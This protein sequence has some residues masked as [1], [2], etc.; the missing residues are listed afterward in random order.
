[1]RP[2]PKPMTVANYELALKRL[3]EPRTASAFDYEKAVAFLV[4]LGIPETHIREGSIPETSL[5][6]II[7]VLA[8]RLPPEQ[9]TT[10][11]HVGNYA[12]LSLTALAAA[13]IARHVGSLVV[14]VDANLPHRGTFHTQDIV[15][16]LLDR[17][18]LSANVILICGY[19]GEKAPSNNGWVIDGYD[20]AARILD[21]AAPTGVLRSLARLVTR[22]FDWVLVDGNHDAVYLERD[23]QNLVPLMRPGGLVFL[24]DCTDWWPAIKRIFASYSTQNQTAWQPLGTDGRIGVLRLGSAGDLP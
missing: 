6:Y 9:A 7:D 19:S 20:P 2:T 18:A 23:L 13:A 14:A 12:G 1:M 22:Q 24:D 11:L 10:G 21:E 17:Y 4:A 8:R 16:K 15:C 5:R 3:K